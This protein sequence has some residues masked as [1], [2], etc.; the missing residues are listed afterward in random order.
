MSLVEQAIRDALQ[1]EG[2]LGV[3]AATL[4][5]GASLMD[6]GLT[7]HAAVAVLLEIEDALGIEMP[8]DRMTPATFASIGSLTAVCGELVPA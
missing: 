3:D 4:P 8:E 6:V 5:A 7:S 1:E 2:G